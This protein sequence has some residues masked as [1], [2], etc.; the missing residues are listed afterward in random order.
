[1][2][3][4]GL[5]LQ[6]E[7]SDPVNTGTTT[8]S[9]CSSRGAGAGKGCG[10]HRRLSISEHLPNDGCTAESPARPAG[11]ITHTSPRYRPARNSRALRFDVSPTRYRYRGQAIVDTTV[12]YTLCASDRRHRYGIGPLKSDS[13]KTSAARRCG[14][15]RA[16]RGQGR[17]V[18][19]TTTSSAACE[20]A[21][22]STRASLWGGLSSPTTCDGPTRCVLALESAAA[23]SG[24]N[25]FAWS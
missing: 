9:A 11:S 21:L 4:R 18:R 23:S 1:M 7:I 15:R 10:A 6:R 12:S 5:T 20:E 22:L 3:P 13:L 2:V 24:N 16:P 25:V 8:G 14:S 19:S 17:R